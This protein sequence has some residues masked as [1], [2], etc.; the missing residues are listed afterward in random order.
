MRN[1]TIIFGAILVFLGIYLLGRSLGLFWFSI[2]DIFRMLIP[3]GL[4]VLGIW[5]IIRKRGQVAMSQ[6]ETSY[7]ADF[8]PP[9]PPPPPGSPAAP[10]SGAT[11]TTPPPPP[12]SSASFTEHPS[13][14]ADGALKY[15]KFLGDMVIDF[16]GI[17]L[18]NIEV[19]DGIGDI[20]MRLKGGVL[21]SGLNRLVIAGFI[22]D[23]RIF[24]PEGMAWFA[25]CSNFIGDVEL[26]ER[27]ASGFGNNLDGQS[28]NYETAAEKVY[29]AANSFIGDIKVISW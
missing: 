17:S 7:H 23:I 20:E 27:R 21:S 25:H 11:F 29:I 12:G 18:Q 14:Q 26:A 1:K 4:I 6:A 15:S 22:G 5:L 3:L 13:G 10:A 8:Q 2:G 28:A 19:S 16:K 24:I 9:P